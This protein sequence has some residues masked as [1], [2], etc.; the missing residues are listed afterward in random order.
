MRKLVGVSLVLVVLA[1]LLGGC[2]GCEQIR[3]PA[4][5]L[6][7]DLEVYDELVEPK[8][9][10]TLDEAVKVKVLGKRIR[11]NMSTLAEAAK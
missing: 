2:C 3:Q 9:G 5:A 10:L 11:V 1:A 6:V 4:A 8:A 7:A